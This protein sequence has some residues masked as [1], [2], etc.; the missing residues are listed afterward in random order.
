[1]DTQTAAIMH[2]LELLYRYRDAMSE[3]RRVE[4]EMIHTQIIIA[5]T[6]L[7][8]IANKQGE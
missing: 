3:V 5:E 8:S 6:Y 7:Q 2:Y 4:D 1:M